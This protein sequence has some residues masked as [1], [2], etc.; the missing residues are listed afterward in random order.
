MEQKTIQIPKAPQPNFNLISQQEKQTNYS[1]VI[2]FLGLAL[3][4]I[5]LVIFFRKKK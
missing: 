3:I 4:I 5:G 2:V 1:Y